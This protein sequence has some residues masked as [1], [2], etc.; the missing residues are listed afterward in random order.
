MAPGLWWRERRVGAAADA[1]GALAA[2]AVA[3]ARRLAALAEV[4]D[5]GAHVA[6]AVRRERELA[7]G[8]AV[9]GR[10]VRGHERDVAVLVDKVE[11][12]GAGIAVADETDDVGAEVDRRRIEARH[13]DVAAGLQAVA[14]D[15]HCRELAAGPPLRVGGGG[16]EPEQKAR[17][18]ASQSANGHGRRA[19][20]ATSVRFA[21]RLAQRGGPAR[22]TLRYLRLHLESFKDRTMLFTLFCCFSTGLVVY[23]I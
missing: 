21:R 1:L 11:V 9:G 15:R 23:C 6:A 7:R 12:L 2:R 8:P 10:L 13:G 18:E 5:G 4:R 20:P 19:D 17:D 22:R 14:H 3:R 16:A